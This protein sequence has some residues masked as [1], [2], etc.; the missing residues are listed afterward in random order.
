[1]GAPRPPTEHQRPIVLL[2]CGWRRCAR[3]RRVGLRRFSGDEAPGV[4]LGILVAR[5]AVQTKP[6]A[7][8]HSGW[9]FAQVHGPPSAPTEGLP[10][11]VRFFRGRELIV[12]PTR[13]ALHLGARAAGVLAAYG[14]DCVTLATFGSSRPGVAAKATGEQSCH[15]SNPPSP[16]GTTALTVRLRAVRRKRSEGASRRSPPRSSLGRTPRLP[17]PPRMRR[18]DRNGVQRPLTASAPLVKML[19]PAE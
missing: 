8:A 17:R 13:R 15:R 18:I 7:P 10:V 12:Q 3:R 4:A 5:P 19:P 9:W 16:P 1:M 14:T 6:A 2:G 11:P